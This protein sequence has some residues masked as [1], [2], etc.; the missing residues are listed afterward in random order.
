MPFVVFT[1]FTGELILRAA[2]SAIDAATAR[3][4]APLATTAFA[5]GGGAM[6]S[7]CAFAAIPRLTAFADV[8]ATAAFA[9]F[10]GA[11]TA[12]AFLGAELAVGFAAAFLVRAGLA[13]AKA[14]V[15]FCEAIVV[16]ALLVEVGFFAFALFCALVAAVLRASPAA[17][18]LDG[19]N[20]FEEALRDDAALRPAV[21]VFAG[22]AAEF[23]EVATRDL[24]FVVALAF[25]EVVF[26]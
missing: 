16:F 8:A 14:L 12:A 6:I 26:F 25:A 18:A 10:F 3:A 23:D 21:L 4:V 17:L 20:V 1:G 2:A 9:V 11:L 19:V 13:A 7:R 5:V 24:L 22:E 15:D